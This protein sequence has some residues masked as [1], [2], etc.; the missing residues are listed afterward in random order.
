[1]FAVLERGHS[2]NGSHGCALSS[3]VPRHVR[4]RWRSALAIYL[5]F[6]SCFA[7]VKIEIGKN[8]TP[9]KST[10]RIIKQ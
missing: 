10:I 6:P 5:R 8:D 3:S 2:H 1:M 4:P 7:S 9:A